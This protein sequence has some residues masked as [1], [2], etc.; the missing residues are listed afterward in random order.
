MFNQCVKLYHYLC[1]GTLTDRIQRVIELVPAVNLIGANDCRK[2]G[3]MPRE[4]RDT[5]MIDRLK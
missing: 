4:I 5:A 2:R 3:I 1:K